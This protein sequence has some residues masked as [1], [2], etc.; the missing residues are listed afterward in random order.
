VLAS[1][2]L[3]QRVQQRLVLAR[4]QRQHLAGLGEQPFDHGAGDVVEAV[5]AGEVTIA[6]RD[7]EL[8]GVA[9]RKGEWLGL[10]EG[11][12]VA[13]GT[14]FEEVA[15]A[16][17]EGLVA[18]PRGLLTLLVGDDEPPLD[19]LLERIAASHPGLELDVQEG[20]Q[21]HYHLLLSAE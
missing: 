9:I 2:P 17:V 7:V 3:E 21:P 1:D 4:Q 11:K 5:A 20:G 15:Y 6:S 10:V 13:G 12:P 19:G 18:E 14:S 16:V 8:D